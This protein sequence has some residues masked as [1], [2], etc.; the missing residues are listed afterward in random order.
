MRSMVC[1]FYLQDW[2]YGTV[3]VANT[4]ASSTLKQKTT[5]PVRGFLFLRRPEE[6]LLSEG[7]LR[8]Q[9]NHAQHVG[10]FLFSGLKLRDQQSYSR[11]LHPEPHSN[12]CGFFL[13]TTEA[14]V[15]YAFPLSHG[16]QAP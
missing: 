16:T 5:T 9:K 6:S 2:S 15:L 14:Q 10:C 7:Y 8:K 4:P 3:S 13:N 1:A 12:E 11:Q